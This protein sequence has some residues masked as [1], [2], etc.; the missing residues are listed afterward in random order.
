[1]RTLTSKMVRTGIKN[2]F[3]VRDFCKKYN[4]KG[5]TSFLEQLD[6]AF[7]NAGADQA[8]RE[9]RK[10]EKQLQHH[11]SKKSVMEATTT[12]RKGDDKVEKTTQKLDVLKSTETALSNEVINLENQHKE[13]ATERRECL[14]ELR[15][16]QQKVDEI[17]AELDRQHSLYKET[18]G[19]ANQIIRQMN[20][21][22]GIRAGKLSELTS[23]REQIKKLET[24]TIAVYK[25][26]DFEV[27]EGAKITAEISEDEVSALT[28][29][30]MEEDIC[31][32]LTIKQIKILSRL[33]LISKKSFQKVEFIFDSSALEKAYLASSLKPLST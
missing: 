5:E 8:L 19:K 30:L 6:R 13:L 18:A 25:D 22:S 27:V 33:I 26:C 20:Q 15:G 12:S 28:H 23:V 24:T 9:I 29:K 3:T 1:M 17:C 16:I 32:E 2:G 31:E 4:I 21:L 7:P 14:Q 11:K 10:N